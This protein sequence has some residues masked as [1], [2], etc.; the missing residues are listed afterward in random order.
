MAS[1]VTRYVRHS[2][3]T[4]LAYLYA[5]IFRSYGAHYDLETDSYKYLAPP[6]QVSTS[7]IWSSAPA[8]ES[9]A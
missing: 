4:S 2:F 7:Q 6:E 3:R 8:I 1:A 5:S 9:K